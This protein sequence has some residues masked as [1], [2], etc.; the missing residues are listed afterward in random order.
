MDDASWGPSSSVNEIEKLVSASAVLL[1]EVPR[2]VL[3]NLSDNVFVAS[4]ALIRSMHTFTGR[5]PFW[6]PC[7]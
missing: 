3:A 7:G 1:A 2:N 5:A 6:N 4:D